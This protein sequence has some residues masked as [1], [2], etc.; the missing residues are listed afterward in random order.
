MK[1]ANGLA[2]R[3]EELIVTCSTVE[4]WRQ[5]RYESPAVIEALDALVSALREEVALLRQYEDTAGKRV[6][7][8]LLLTCTSSGNGAV[9]RLHLLQ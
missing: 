8:R 9:G 7:V 1:K 5:T 6:V 3:I 2:R 4:Q